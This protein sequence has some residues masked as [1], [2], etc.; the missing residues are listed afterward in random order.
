MLTS[1]FDTV[2]RFCGELM[3]AGSFQS[4]QEQVNGLKLLSRAVLRLNVEGV[5]VSTYAQLALANTVRYLIESPQAK[6]GTPDLLYQEAFA[7]Y[8]AALF[9][10]ITRGSL[11]VSVSFASQCLNDSRLREQALRELVVPLLRR[12]PDSIEL[13]ALYNFAIE[14]SFADSISLSEFALLNIGQL[15]SLTSDRQ[16]RLL[17]R[18]LQIAMQDWGT[19]GANYHF[20]FS[21][22]VSRDRLT[23]EDLRSLHAE[24]VRMA[25][26]RGIDTSDEHLS[27][28]LALAGQKGSSQISGATGLDNH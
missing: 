21:F 6:P 18:G 19:R 22:V 8:F 3:S 13:L 16:F 27:M 15:G 7:C 14:I 5:V 17:Q 2:A 26:E 23:G 10:S 11:S 1:E 12:F 24:I 4:V 20:A 25:A 9:P 28:M